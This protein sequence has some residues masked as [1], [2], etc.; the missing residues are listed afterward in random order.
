MSEP[1]LR[2]AAV[3]DRIAGEVVVGG[4]E[5]DSVVERS[6]PQVAVSVLQKR[7]YA[8][9]DKPGKTHLLVGERRDVEFGDLESHGPVLGTYEQF[10]WRYFVEEVYA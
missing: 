7:V 5:D 9:V 10:A 6:E 2:V 8:R 3:E 1:V 4:E